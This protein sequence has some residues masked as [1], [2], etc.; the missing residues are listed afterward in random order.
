MAV[1]TEGEIQ[2]TLTDAEEQL[3][4]E[5]AKLGG[6]QGQLDRMDKLLE[7]SSAQNSGTGKAAP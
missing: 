2:A 5:Q 4:M 1:N 6:L 7:N 3:R